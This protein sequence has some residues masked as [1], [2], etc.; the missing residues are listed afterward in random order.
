[1]GSLAWPVSLKIHEILFWM[2]RWMF[3]LEMGLQL[4]A[5]CVQSPISSGSDGV[6]GLTSLSYKIHTMLEIL[7]CRLKEW[8]FPW[9]F[10]QCQHRKTWAL[11]YE[12]DFSVGNPHGIAIE[13]CLCAVFL[14]ESMQQGRSNY[15]YLGSETA[16]QIW[17]S[18]ATHN[19]KFIFQLGQQKIDYFSGI[20]YYF[21]GISY[22]HLWWCS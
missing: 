6:A 20:L 21:S 4:N 14:N 10:L 17:A 5:V 12:L 22:V 19:L 18:K 15:Q 11:Q 13:F 16:S 9:S 8:D 1:M 2:W 7:F 3:Q